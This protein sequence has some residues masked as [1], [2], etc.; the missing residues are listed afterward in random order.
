MHKKIAMFVTVLAVALPINSAFA[1]MSQANFEERQELR[2]QNEEAREQNQ[3]ERQELR[4]QRQQNVQ[5]KCKNIEERLGTRVNRY[6]NGKQ[7]F[8]TVF[9]NMKTRLTRLS[10]RLASKGIDTTKLNKDIATL[11]T[12]IDKLI[13]DNDAFIAEIKATQSAAPTACGT[14]KGEFMTKLGEARKFS[15][16]VRQDRIEIRNFFQNTI[17]ADITAIRKQLEKVKASTTPEIESSTTTST[18]SSQQ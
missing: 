17:K 16:T 13:A 11:S 8:M 14:S 1:K 18:S 3:T 2:E 10:E 15:Q 6:E 5:D 4:E 7:M 12:K 9:G